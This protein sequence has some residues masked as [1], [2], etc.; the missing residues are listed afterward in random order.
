MDGPQADD[1]R[2]QWGVRRHRIGPSAGVRRSLCCPRARISTAYAKLGVPAEHGLSWILPRLVG[3][4][5]ALDLLLSS[6]PVEAEEAVKIGL[7]TR[8]CDAD[9]VLS[10]AVAYATTLA[11]NCSPRS[12]ATI[13]RQVWGDLSR[14]Y[15]EAN[16]GWFAAMRTSTALRTRTSPKG[17]R[18]FV[19]RRP[20]ASNRSPRM[21]SCRRFLR[22]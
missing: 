17:C 7:A 20:P 22:S 16:A 19:Q 4:E 21:S 3:V 1:R 11:K 13:R 18:R 14:G 2:H 8:I 9:T 15:T 5:W 6:R 12:M 10:E